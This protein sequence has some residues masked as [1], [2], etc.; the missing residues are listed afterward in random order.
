MADDNVR[1]GL[2]VLEL[3]GALIPQGALVKGV[4]SGWRFAW[5]ALMRELAPQAR[6]RVRIPSGGVKRAAAWKGCW[7]QHCT[8]PRR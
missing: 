2:N 3:T 6:P 5:T 7:A 8:R 1:K 4:K